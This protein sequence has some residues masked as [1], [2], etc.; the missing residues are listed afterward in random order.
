[1]Q[2]DSAVTCCVYAGGGRPLLSRA[3]ATE[4]PDRPTEF[5]ARNWPCKS[6]LPVSAT[7]N[8]NVIV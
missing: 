5:T 1:M 6:T 3:D 4:T 2:E 8:K 7:M